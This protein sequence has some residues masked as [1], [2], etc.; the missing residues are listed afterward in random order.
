MTRRNE[1]DLK[2]GGCPR[3]I[4]VLPAQHL[5]SQPPS[6]SFSISITNTAHSTSTAAIRQTRTSS[7]MFLSTLLILSSA[8]QVLTMPVTAP[9]VEE[10]QTAAQCV[11]G[12]LYQPELYNIYQYPGVIPFQSSAKAVNIMSGSSSGSV[13]DQVARWRVPASA[14]QCTVGWVSYSNIM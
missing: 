6:F 4:V 8:V 7:N 14:K 5:H 12:K 3:K 1:S 2:V 9:K 10:R 13:Q 11:A